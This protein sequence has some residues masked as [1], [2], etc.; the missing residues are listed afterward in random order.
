ML[1]KHLFIRCWRF[2]DKCTQFRSYTP[3]WINTWLHDHG[4]PYSVS[5]W[6][7]WLL[8]G[9]IMQS[10]SWRIFQTSALFLR[11]VVCP[12]QEVSVVVFNALQ[13]ARTRSQLK[14]FVKQ[15]HSAGQLTAADIWAMLAEGDQHIVNQIIHYGANLWGTHAY[16]TACHHELMDFIWQKGTPD[17]F[18]TLSTADM[19]WPDLHWHMPQTENPTEDPKVACQR[20]QVMLYKNLHI[21]A[22]YYDQQL[23]VYF[24]HIFSPLLGICHF[25]YHYEWQERGSSH[26][27]GFFWLHDG[28]RANKIDWEVLKR[29][30]TI[31]S[32]EQ[33]VKMK[34]FMEYW[35]RIVLTSSP[36]PHQDKNMPLLGEHPCSLK[37]VTLKNIK[38]ELADLLNWTE[39]HTKCMPGYCLIK[40][41]VPGCDEPQVCC[42]FDYPMPLWEEAGVGVD[43]K[44]QVHFKPKRI[45]QLMNPYNPAMILGWHANIDLHVTVHISKPSMER[46][47]KFV[48][49]DHKPN[50]H[51]VLI[52]LNQNTQEDMEAQS[53]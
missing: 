8:S 49:F 38:Q 50:H 48:I 43:S 30:D 46:P 25:W 45:D 40:W 3:L 47:H 27:H 24:K 31:I 28:L 13:Q 29:A 23:Q 15:Q 19:Q 18:W 14:V 51:G 17:M 20:R 41:R 11:W 22:A 2:K 33:T 52:H 32:D 6:C 9:S 5:G 26:I 44:G 39:Q 16:W 21:A 4:I 42:R 12:T 10:G 1:I 7:W 53:S 35:N 37:W 34:N 36:F